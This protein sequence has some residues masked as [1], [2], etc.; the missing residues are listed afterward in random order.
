[1]ALPILSLAELTRRKPP[2]VELCAYTPASLAALVPGLAPGTI[3][4]ITGARSSGRTALVQ[5]ALAAATQEGELCALVDGGSTF[6]PAS[7]QAAGIVL[8]RL[9]WVQCG[10]HLQHS[11]Q[12]ADLI[13]S[14]GGF[15]VM[16][17]DLCEFRAEEL[18]RIPHSRWHR[19]RLAVE[20]TPG[21]LLITAGQ[22]VARQSAT[23]QIQL[24]PRTA[25]WSGNLLRGW[26]LEASLRKPVRAETARL[27]VLAG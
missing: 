13:L 17:L 5:A 10:R 24:A 3:T 9:L 6:C 16:V 20:Q 27:R 11:L 25:H 8:D 26:D 23:T 22:P 12:A 19:F 21:M 1:M 14:G 2:A 15:R 7:A 4:E 18:Q